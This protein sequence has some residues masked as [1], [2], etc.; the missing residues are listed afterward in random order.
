MTGLHGTLGVVV[1]RLLAVLPNLVGVVIIT[2]LLTRPLPGDPAAC[3]AGGAATQEAVEKVRKALGL[4]RSLP[5]QFM[6]YVADLARGDLGVSLTTGQPV[7]TELRRG[8]DLATLLVSHD[9]DVVRLLT[10][11]VV[12]MY[13]GKI[14]EKGPSCS[15]FEH[16]AH[17]YKWALA[18]SIPGHGERIRLDGEIASPIDPPPRFCRFQSRCPESSDRCLREAPALQSASGTHAAACHF[19]RWRAVAAAA[20]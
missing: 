3:F 15:I 8:L 1:R 7:L 11:D 12:V 18:S 4:D 10:D 13:L 6:H 5:E 20:A 17:Q 16:P 9:L 14:V 2:F 19:A